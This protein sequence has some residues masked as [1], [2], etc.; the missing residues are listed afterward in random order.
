MQIT[1]DSIHALGTILCVFAHPDD[2]TCAMGGIMAVA[3]A[4]GQRVVCVTATRGEQGVQDEARWPQKDLA[5]VRSAELSGA[6][7]HLGVIE[8]HFLDYPDGQCSHVD[9]HKASGE[10]AGFITR[11]Q[12]DSILTFGP[13]GLTGHADHRAVSGWAHDAAVRAGGDIQLFHAV[14]SQP[15]YAGMK[16]ADTAIN[17]FFATEHPPV[18]GT[19]LLDI[20]L[21]LDDGLYQK[22]L[23]ALRAMP[24]QYHALFSQV[25]HEDLRAGFGEECFVRAEA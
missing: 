21:V 1:A 20:R 5:A 22:K 13:D 3:S 9:R 12:P 16:A 24:S 7:A 10:I 19:D 6:L 4:G 8:H 14:L 18:V 17:M 25:S 11:Y 23:A 15:Q 2:E